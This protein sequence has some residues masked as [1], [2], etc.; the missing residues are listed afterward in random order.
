METVRHQAMKMSLAEI[1]HFQDLQGMSRLLSMGILPGIKHYSLILDG[2]RFSIME[3][4]KIYLYGA[5]TIGLRVLS[6][7]RSVGLE[8]KVQGF[9]ETKK[10]TVLGNES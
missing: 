5:G 7:L 1:L 9:I 2:L 8:E 3:A 4:S 10:D 6:Y